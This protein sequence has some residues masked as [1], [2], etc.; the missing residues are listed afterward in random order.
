MSFDTGFEMKYLVFPV[1]KMCRLSICCVFP[2]KAD[3]SVSYSVD[4][5]P[6]SGLRRYGLKHTDH[7]PT[8]QDAEFFSA[9]HP[10]TVSGD[11]LYL[12]LAW[13]QEDRY[14]CKLYA[15]DE[16]VKS[17]EIYALEDDLLM[18]HPLKGDHHMHTYMSDG[19]DS[20]MYMAAAA[21]RHGYDYCVITDHRQYEPSLI[22]RDFF[23]PTGVDFLVIPGEEVHSPDNPVHIINLG[24]AHSVNDWWRD[25]EDEYRAAVQQEMAAMDEPMLDADRYTAAASQVMFDRIRQ[26]GGVA[27]LC[28]P[29]WIISRGF[30]EHEDVTDYLFD[31]KRFDALELIAG[32]AY[33]IGTQMQLSYYNDRE[34]MPILGNSDAHG[35]FGDKL[36]PGNYTIAFADALDG[37]AIK[38][39]IRAGLTVA[40]NENRFYG[41]YRLVK[42]AY[43][44]QQNYFPMHR[45]ERDV[46]G[47]RMLRL[48]SSQSHDEA[49]VADLQSVRPTDSFAPRRYPC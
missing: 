23:A 45:R 8:A 17:M 10:L 26:E 7:A 5:S 36:E 46:L 18:K 38:D 30:N 27:V 47:S 42:Y 11:E 12:E 34:N 28:H 44:L 48:A 24:G 39:A 43:F 19:K 16:L 41:D 4:I 49:L 32:G 21:C 25:H 20:P 6:F 9:R 15:N 31:H 1:R 37:E 33:E 14:I 29:H 2:M 35:C 22:A 40:A 13:P 3:P